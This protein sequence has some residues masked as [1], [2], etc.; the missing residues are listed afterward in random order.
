MRVKVVDFVAAV[1]C[2]GL[3]DLLTLPQL[4]QR[5]YVGVAQA[6]ERDFLD[7]PAV[8]LDFLHAAPCARARDSGLGQQVGKLATESA[9]CLLFVSFRLLWPEWVCGLG[10]FT[11]RPQLCEH[12]IERRGNRYEH[13]CPGLARA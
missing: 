10:V 4:G 12:R 2:Q 7:R 1:P 13:G 11:L 8:S 5:G 3:D 9:A 6:M